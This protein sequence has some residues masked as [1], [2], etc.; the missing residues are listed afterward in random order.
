MINRIMAG[1]YL[2]IPFCRRKCFYCDFYSIVQLEKQNGFILAL[3]N[4]IK[5]YDMDFSSC[6]NTIF[7]GGGTPSLISPEIIEDILQA[8]KSQFKIT[9]ISEVT[10]ECNPANLTQ[11]K[12][13]G[14]KDAGVNRISL[15][16][17]SFNDTE[18]KFLQRIHDSK[19]AVKAVSMAKTAGFDNLSIDLIYGIPR[20]T[21]ETWKKTLDI[22]LSLN[23]QHISAYSLG[24][25]PGTPMYNQWKNGEISQMDDDYELML[26]EMLCQR[27]EDE[28]YEHYEI[29]NFALP[30][31]RSIHNYNYWG[32]DI[33]FGFGPSAHS[34]DGKR[35]YWNYSDLDLYTKKI[36]ANLKPVEEDEEITFDKKL[37]ESIMLSF[38][39]GVVQLEDLAG[40]IGKNKRNNILNYFEMLEKNGFI[41]K[42]GESINLTAKG[43]FYSDELI[44]KVYSFLTK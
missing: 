28:G 32:K 35:R 36:S 2:H 39:C 30:G 3:K 9:R 13:R 17:Q 43:F 4:E 5:L 21:V 34:F 38:R 41:I 10:L 20:Q 1:F 29:S 23:L 26:Y 16:V 24:Y 7:I 22:A 8:L 6:D 27:L 11:D 31:N 19:C 42:K 14:Y 37:L 44:I 15:G 40:K 18:L 33:Y 25:E 12:L